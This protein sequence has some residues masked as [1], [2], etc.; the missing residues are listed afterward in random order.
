VKQSVLPVPIWKKV[1]KPIDHQIIWW[2]LDISAP[3]HVLMHGWQMVAAAQ[4]G[5][6]RI[7]M[8]RRVQV[9]VAAG[10]LIEGQRKGEVMLNVNIFDRQADRSKVRMMKV[11]KRGGE[12]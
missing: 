12:K 3:G 11:G 6:H 10:I 7:T 1:I 4:L 5:I 9:L 2:M 8:R